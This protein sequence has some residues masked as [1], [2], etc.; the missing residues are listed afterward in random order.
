MPFPSLTI[1]PDYDLSYKKS[2][3]DKY[4]LKA[5]DVRELRFPKNVTPGGFY[6]EVTLNM[7]DII[8]SVII[9]TLHTPKDASYTT[10]IFNDDNPYNIWPP[11]V[12]SIQSFA[13]LTTY[14]LNFGKC[15]TMDVPLWIVALEVGL[16][17]SSH[18][19]R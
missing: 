5:D 12:L 1:C 15:Y 4:G 14:Y 2:V 8:D 3:L 9:E 11:E 7:D 10:F 13:F 19:F 18:F 17:C 6:D 16:S